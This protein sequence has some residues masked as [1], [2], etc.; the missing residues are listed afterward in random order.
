MRILIFLVYGLIV[1]FSIILTNPTTLA[2]I[3]SIHFS[4]FFVLSSMAFI[5]LQL[6]FTMS[7]TGADSRASALDGIFGFIPIVALAAGF[8]VK[9]L[10]IDSQL[11]MTDVYF[12]IITIFTTVIDIYMIASIQNRIQALSTQLTRER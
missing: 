11:M 2:I 1:F 12:S 5:V 10:I 7:F 4:M 3:N 8:L 9:I 6:H